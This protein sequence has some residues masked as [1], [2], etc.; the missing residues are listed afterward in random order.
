MSDPSCEELLGGPAGPHARPEPG[1]SVPGAVVCRSRCTP[2]SNQDT[3]HL[4]GG[5]VSGGGELCVGLTGDYLRREDE[6]KRR[7]MAPIICGETF[8]TQ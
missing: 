4:W 5:V 6:W 7:E 8:S 1:S 2:A 3:C